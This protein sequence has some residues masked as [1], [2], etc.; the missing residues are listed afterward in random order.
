SP[1]LPS[2]GY[3]LRV[4]DENSGADVG[5]GEKGVLAIQPPLPPGCLSTV[6]GNDDRVIASYFSHFKELLYS[7]LDWAI[8][9]EDGYTFIRGCTDDVVIVAGHRLGTREIE[10][11]VASHPD[12]AEAAVV[13]VHDEVKGQVP[14]VF[15]TLKRTD[16]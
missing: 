3:R 1:G 5:P 8:S 2:P 12:V 11:S 14:V 6:W 4:L 9:D 13:G 16:T 10:E 15:A 7:S